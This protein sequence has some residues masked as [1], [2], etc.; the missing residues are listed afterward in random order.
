MPTVLHMKQTLG[1]LHTIFVL[2]ILTDFLSGMFPYVCLATMP[3]FCSNNWPK[4][5]INKFQATILKQ[6]TLYCTKSHASLSCI[7]NRREVKPR[8][9]GMILLGLP[10][11]TTWKHKVTVSLLITHCGLQ[12]FL[13]YSH[14]ITK[15][16]T[17]MNAK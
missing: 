7:Y 1:H 8:C 16:S 9:N 6:K 4:K 14:F 17:Y 15:V 13:P 5:I 12:L 3:L 11:K 10:T 2:E